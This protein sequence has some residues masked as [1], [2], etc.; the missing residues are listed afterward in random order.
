[1]LLR[2]RL[3]WIETFAVPILINHAKRL[4]PLQVYNNVFNMRLQM[5]PG[6]RLP[7]PTLPSPTED[8][9]GGQP[10]K[11]GPVLKQRDKGYV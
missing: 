3:R 6:N 9:P 1:M 10:T 2:V 7:C 11:A 5:A 4:Q 8:L